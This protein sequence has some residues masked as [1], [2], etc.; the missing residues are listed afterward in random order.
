[1]FPS[2]SIKLELGTLLTEVTVR[3]PTGDR[4]CQGY[5]DKQVYNPGLWS[6]QGEPGKS[7]Q[8]W[9]LMRSSFCP[10]NCVWK[11]FGYSGSQIVIEQVREE[12]K[13]T[14]IRKV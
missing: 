3:A 6:L 10:A 12:R 5:L 14:W 2:V 1:M 4:S 13:L 7:A 9:C 8:Q 11:L